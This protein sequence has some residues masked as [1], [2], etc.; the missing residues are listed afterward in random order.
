MKNVPIID[1]FSKTKNIFRGNLVWNLLQNFHED[2]LILQGRNTY[3]ML[4]D[5][6][7]YSCGWLSHLRDVKATS[8]DIWLSKW[9]S[10]LEVYVSYNLE[11][12]GSQNSFDRKSVMD[13]YLVR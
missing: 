12:Y 13:I 3:L 7:A 8:W 2:R 6:L 9:L 5:N 10:K 1:F 11:V 4:F